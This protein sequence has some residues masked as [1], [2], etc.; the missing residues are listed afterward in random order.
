MTL[1]F[2]WW[3]SIFDWMVMV[4]AAES[5]RCRSK[6]KQG[7]ALASALNLPNR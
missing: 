2:L 5:L 6:K 4:V 7:A 3:A 1:I